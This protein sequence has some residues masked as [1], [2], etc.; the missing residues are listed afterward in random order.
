MR[1]YL[2]CLSLANLLFLR[3]W[4]EMYQLRGQFPTAPA[5]PSFRAMFEATVFNVVLA[6]AVLSCV[7]F[8]VRRSGLRWLT[9]LGQCAFLVLCTLPVERLGWIAFEQLRSSLP[10]PLLQVVWALLMVTPLLG[11]VLLAVYSN[12]VMVRGAV[13]VL[14]VA[15]PVFVLNTGNLFWS[16]LRA[17]SAAPVQFAQAT[18]Q[19]ACRRLVWVI[20]DELDQRLAFEKRPPGLKLPELDRLRVESLST[21]AATSPAL[22][23]SES[24]PALITGVLSTGRTG[25]EK[26]RTIFT[27]VREHGWNSAVAGWFLPYCTDMARD[28]MQCTQPAA[29]VHISRNPWA[30][31]KMQ[32]LTKLTE[33]WI[34]TRLNPAAR[35]RVPWYGWADRIQQEAGFLYIREPALSAVAD[36]RFSL[37]FLHFPIPHPLGIYSRRLGQVTADPQSNYLDN[38]ALV[39]RT[40]GQ[41]RA[42]LDQSGLGG[43]TALIVT[44]DHPLRVQRWRESGVWDEEEAAATGNKMGSFVPFL[45]HLPSDG[46]G[47]VYS[48]PFNTVVS[49]EL[50]LAILEGSVTD[51]PGVA[52]WLDAAGDAAKSTV[53]QTALR[54][55][56]L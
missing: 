33:N 25:L 24:V 10:I 46:D 34:V 38:L 13:A 16:I 4:V 26:A 32:W 17:P 52:R 11:C 35:N 1:R 40:L 15:S 14:T 31:V 19:I 30:I 23:T 27:E 56:R 54:R 18:P 47:S 9:T 43:K 55:S 48:K 37:V 20:F 50:A 44:S 42:A 21:T 8:L 36:A 49:K 28:I 7:V 3:F 6:T 45:I 5:S 22:I 29:D 53:H 2:V 12:D 51:Q 41:V 39:D